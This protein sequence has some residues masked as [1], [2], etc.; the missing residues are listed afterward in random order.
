MATYRVKDGIDRVLPGIGQ[1]VNGLITTDATIESP[2]FEL[3]DTSTKPPAP[4]AQLLNPQPP[5]QP[6]A[7]AQPINKEMN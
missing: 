4:T 5:L 1:T 6:Q 2:L 7:P 3:V